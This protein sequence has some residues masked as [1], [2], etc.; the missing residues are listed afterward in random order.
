MCIAYQ[1]GRGLGQDPA[2]TWYEDELRFFDNHVIPLAQK[3]DECGIFG[4]SSY[5]CL[6][7][8]LE[9]RIKWEVTGKEVVDEYRK[10]YSGER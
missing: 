10:K 5:E 2:K 7:Y 8:A 1:L 9:N 6:K 3:L 4:A